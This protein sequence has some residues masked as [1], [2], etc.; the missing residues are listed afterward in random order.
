[1]EKHNHNLNIHY[2]APEEVWD[3]LERLY[4]EMPYWNGIVEGCPSWYGKDGKLVEVSV[5]PSGLQFYAELPQEE[6]DT[7]FGL[8]KRRATEIL[9]YE[10]GEPEDGFE[11]YFWENESFRC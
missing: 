5:E 9:G 2:S 10:V 8:F 1:M 3:G 11:F 6:W 7:W 4:K